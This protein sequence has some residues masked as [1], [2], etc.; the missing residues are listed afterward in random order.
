MRNEAVS[1]YLSTFPT[2]SENLRIRSEESCKNSLL[3]LGDKWLRSRNHCFMYRC[4][5]SEIINIRER[6]FLLHLSSKVKREA[7]RCRIGLQLPIVCSGPFAE[8][9]QLKHAFKLTSSW[10]SRNFSVTTK[11]ML[12]EALACLSPSTPRILPC[13]FL[14]TRLPN[15]I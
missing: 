12:S 14:H 2:F 7:Y 1:Q 11:M 10:S 6:N 15:W 4:F 3:C 13:H 5:L 8:C 9:S